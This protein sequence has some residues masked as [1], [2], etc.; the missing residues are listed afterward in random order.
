[1]IFI[2]GN[3]R[4]NHQAVYTGTWATTLSC[5]VAELMIVREANEACRVGL[6]ELIFVFFPL[7]NFETSE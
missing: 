7:L 3:P 2:K 1:M 5:K 6:E 4:S